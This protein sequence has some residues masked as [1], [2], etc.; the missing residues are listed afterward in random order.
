[1]RRWLAIIAAISAVLLLIV[2]A[3]NAVQIL[4]G[5]AAASGWYIVAM[6]LLIAGLCG[7]VAYLA[8]HAQR[9]AESKP[10]DLTTELQ[11]QL[12]AEMIRQHS[13]KRIDI[14]Q[15]GGMAINGNRVGGV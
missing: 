3:A 11:A 15:D 5:V 4:R 1:M 10:L 6:E 8:S 9:I 13:L 7:L 2:A 14:S 12:A